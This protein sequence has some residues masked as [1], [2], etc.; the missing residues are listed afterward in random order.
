VFL[1]GIGLD[2]RTAAGTDVRVDDSLHPKKLPA[3]FRRAGQCAGGRAHVGEAVGG[4][5]DYETLFPRT[6]HAVHF[7]NATILP[8]ELVTQ[9]HS[10][11]TEAFGESSGTPSP[12][13]AGSRATALSSRPR[14]GRRRPTRRWPRCSEGLPCA[15]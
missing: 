6:G 12:T 9:G 2:L 5:D 15:R 1:G 8:K 13:R 4:L 7:A 10:A 14:A 11:P 3:R